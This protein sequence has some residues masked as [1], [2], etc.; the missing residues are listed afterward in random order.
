MPC[1]PDGMALR[2]AEG[3]GILCPP[4]PRWSIDDIMMQLVHEMTRSGIR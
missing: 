2:K 3:F 1:H 4:S